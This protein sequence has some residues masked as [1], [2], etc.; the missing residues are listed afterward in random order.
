MLSFL[1]WDA[2]PNLVIALAILN[3]PMYYFV[4]TLFWNCWSDF[5]DALRYWYQPLWLSIFI[6]EWTDDYW[7]SIKVFIWL[8]CIFIV[9]HAEFKIMLWLFH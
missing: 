7:E 5:L 1:G 6:R 9:Y 3:I 2:A 4:G 8:L